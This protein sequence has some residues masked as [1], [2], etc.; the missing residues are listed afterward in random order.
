ML[1]SRQET[2]MYPITTSNSSHQKKHFRGVSYRMDLKNA[3]E[4]AEQKRSPIKLSGV[5]RKLNRYD[6]HLEDI[7]VGKL[8]KLEDS[9]L[10]F[11]F[12]LPEKDAVKDLSVEKNKKY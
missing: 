12:T 3:F 8:T 5:K 2:P 6:Q 1:R 7:E 11:D 9:D 4:M 10:N